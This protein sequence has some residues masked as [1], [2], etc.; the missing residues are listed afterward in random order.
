MLSRRALLCLTPALALQAPAA[1][2]L[3]TSMSAAPYTLYDLPVSNNGA[4]V[5][6]LLYYKDVKP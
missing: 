2:R 3:T 4:R 1:R 5:R 6:M